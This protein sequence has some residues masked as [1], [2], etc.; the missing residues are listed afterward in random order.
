[1]EGLWGQSRSQPT[2]REF[3]DFLEALQ[4]MPWSWRN[5][6]QGGEIAVP[7]AVNAESRSRHGSAGREEALRVF[8]IVEIPLLAKAM[9]PES[10]PRRHGATENSNILLKRRGMK[11][12]MRLPTLHKSGEVWATRQ[13]S[14]YHYQFFPTILG[15]I[16]ALVLLI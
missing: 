14:S 5:N 6:P 1:V 13:S 9:K 2:N 7:L 11:E 8:F 12:A 10:S 3:I 15:S 16:C 4:E